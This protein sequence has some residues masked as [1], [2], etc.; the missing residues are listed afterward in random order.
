MKSTVRHVEM[1]E[2][3]VFSLPNGVVTPY[4]I[5]TLIS[6]AFALAR[7][8]SKNHM[9]KKIIV[10]QKNFKMITVQW[11]KVSFPSIPLSGSNAAAACRP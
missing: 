8:M 11:K 4:F 7:K 6:Q 2:K 9:N 10:Y 1:Y 3:S 5:I